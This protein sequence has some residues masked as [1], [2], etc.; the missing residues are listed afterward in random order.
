MSQSYAS[1]SKHHKYQSISREGG[2]ISIK[3]LVAGSN[4]TAVGV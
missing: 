4:T 2:D 3:G 1:L